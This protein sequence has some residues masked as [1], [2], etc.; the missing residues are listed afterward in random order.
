[1]AII[2]SEDGYITFS[3]PTDAKNPD[4]VLPTLSEIIDL[5]N[6]EELAHSLINR[7]GLVTNN[8]VQGTFV[9]M[10][11]NKFGIMLGQEFNPLIF[12]GSNNDYVFM[13]NSQRYEL[14]D[15]QERIRHSIDW[16]KKHEFLKLVSNTPYCTRTQRFKVLDYNYEVDLEAIAKH[17]NYMSDYLD[18]TRNMMVAYFFAYTYL[19]SERNQVLPIDNFEKYSPTLYIGNL[20]ELKKQTPKTVEKIGMQPVLR[21][22]V[23]QSMSINVAEDG[24]KI[25]SLFKKIELPKNPAVARNIFAQFEGGKLLFPADYMTRCAVQI[26]EHGTLQEEM[27]ERYCDETKTDITWLRSEYKKMG[28]ELINQP[29]D[30][31][32]QAKYMINREIDEFIIPY[33]N[34]SFIFRGVRRDLEKSGIAENKNEELVLSK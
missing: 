26:R 15:G 20:K 17:Y 6:D 8:E 19:D 16:I 3:I 31:P 28:F 29:W 22:K 32:E 24:E 27:I 14:A 13:P 34:S 18:I 30:I 4:I 25:K 11:P 12:R 9:E 1:M 10:K 7:H 21:A 5:M 2:Q 23:Q 33:L